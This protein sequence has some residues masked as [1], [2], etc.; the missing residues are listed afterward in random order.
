MSSLILI[1]ALVALVTLPSALGLYFNES[2]GFG[3]EE[4]YIPDGR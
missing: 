3:R 1:I 4:E 2:R